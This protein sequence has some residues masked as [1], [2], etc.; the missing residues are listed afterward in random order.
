[1]LVTNSHSYRLPLQEYHSKFPLR[2]SSSSCSKSMVIDKKINWLTLQFCD[3]G[4]DPVKIINN[5][6][7]FHGCLCKS[8]RFIEYRAGQ[9]RL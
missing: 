1:M 9:T 5:K 8:L 6:N 4:T 3:C 2:I 7:Y